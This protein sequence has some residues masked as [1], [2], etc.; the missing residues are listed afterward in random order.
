VAAIRRYRA[1]V[2]I[3]RLHADE[4]VLA[5]RQRQELACVE[6]QRDRRRVAPS[7][8]PAGWRVIVA[9]EESV[10]GADG[11]DNAGALASCRSRSWRTCANEN[12]FTLS[13]SLR[14]CRVFSGLGSERLW[15]ALA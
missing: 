14:L 5:L 11:A 9:D 6:P 8:Q 12:G 15:K 3:A 4:R 2:A 10:E 13:G 7:R 1:K